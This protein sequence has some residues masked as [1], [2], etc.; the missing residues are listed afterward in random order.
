MGLLDR[1]LG[2]ARRGR[3]L[4]LGRG[5]LAVLGLL[6]LAPTAALT[7][8]RAFPQVDVVFE[9]TA[10]H[11]VV[12]SAIAACALL[13]ALVAALVAARARHPSLVLLALGCVSIGVLM[14]G[15]G[16]TTPGIFGR[17]VNMW[18]ARFPVLAMAGFALS[19]AA[20]L[21][22]EGSLT[23]R[24]VARYPRGLLIGVVAV[25]TAGS[26]VVVARPDAIL[27]APFPGEELLSR[28][29]V[30]ASGIV[31]LIAGAVHYRRWRLGGD[32]IEMALMLASWLSADAIVAFQFGQ[33][34]RVSWWDY[35]I[36]LLAGFAAAAWAVLVG[37]RRTR[38][39]EGALASISV[40]DPLEH[41]SRGYPD[42]L[43]ALV[44]AVE[45]KDRYIHGHSARVADLSTRIGLHMGLSPDA[46]RNLS[47]GAVLHDIGKIGVPDGIL[48]KPGVL[49]DEEWEWIRAHPVSGWEMARRA[50]S[51]RDALGVIRHHHERW[52]GSGYP[53]GLMETRIPMTARIATVADVWDALT[54]DRAYRSAWPADEALRHIVDARGS[55]FD[56]SC[57]EAFVDLMVEQENVSVAQ[58]HV[59]PRVLEMAARA[60]HSRGDRVRSSPG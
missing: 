19:L 39:V 37:F 55:L 15:H 17:P 52:D 57:V 36:Y 32:R 51:L 58:V 21:A 42:A 54:S 14:L 43:H 56:P 45:A 35:H 23:Y 47:T 12:V 9:S 33:I 5:G 8:L 40:R 4:G 46:L 28:G 34:W 48:N 60:C 30:I 24:F 59:D 53:D 2:L 16:L 29:V 44:G 41:I 27:G 31:F 18:V 3:R 7:A 49:S 20:A 26:V 10:F 22:G 25:L 1:P 6:L 50:P 13:V 11:L 38:S